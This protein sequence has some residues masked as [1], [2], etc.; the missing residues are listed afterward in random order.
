MHDSFLCFPE[1]DALTRTSSAS[2]STSQN[3]HNRVLALDL[4]SARYAFESH[5]VRETG[6]WQREQAFEF[7]TVLGA[8]AVLRKDDLRQARHVS[9]PRRAYPFVGP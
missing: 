5:L 4:S 6:A 3:K 7:G 2:P 9:P 1:S 8:F